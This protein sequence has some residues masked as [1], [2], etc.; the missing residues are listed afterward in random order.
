MSSKCPKELYK[1]GDKKHAPYL[2]TCSSSSIYGGPYAAS[3]CPP[4]HCLTC[5]APPWRR[6]DCKVS[7][8]PRNGMRPLNPVRPVPSLFIGPHPSECR[9]KRSRG[10]Q[11]TMTA[12]S[13]QHDKKEGMW[14][15]RKRSALASSVPWILRHQVHIGTGRR[16]MAFVSGGDPAVHAAWRQSVCSQKSW[17][18]QMEQDQS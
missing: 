13:P 15:T 11:M 1:R 10:C 2:R 7:H 8:M 5:P 17:S 18:V 6:P 9:N 12:S 3:P 16:A 4:A 14:R